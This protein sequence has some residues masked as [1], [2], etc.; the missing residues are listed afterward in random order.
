MNPATGSVKLAVM[1]VMQGGVV[2]GHATAVA[3]PEELIVAMPVSVDPQ[4][5]ISVISTVVGAALY[6]PTAMNCEVSPIEYNVCVPAPGNIVMAD[7]ALCAGGVPGLKVREAVPTIVPEIG[8]VAV[9]EM[10]VLQL[11]DAHATAVATPNDG[12]IDAT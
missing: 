7:S 6:V 10:V 12:S 3:S 11:E 4:V 9:A 5:A 1:F 2:P 8:S